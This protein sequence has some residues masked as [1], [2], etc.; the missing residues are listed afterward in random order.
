M[1]VRDYQGLI[2][3]YA[4]AQGIPPAMVAA[5][6]QEESGGDPNAENLSGGDAARGGS[7]GLMQVSL[8][9]AQG[10]GYTGDASGLLDPDTNLEY[11]TAYLGD[12]FREYGGDVNDTIAAYNAG[13]PRHVNG[14]P[15]QPYTNEGY[16]QAVLGFMQQYGGA[17][18]G[19]LLLVIAGVLVW[20][21]SRGKA[22]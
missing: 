21:F 8:L 11:A 18:G 3:Q 6:M 20:I 13:S 5:I 14:D 17:I 22:A 12:L 16:V 7:Y 9:T 10:Y 2:N 1:S 4:G 15:S 19:G